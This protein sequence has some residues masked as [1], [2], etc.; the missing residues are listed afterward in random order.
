MLRT[1]YRMTYKNAKSFFGKNSLNVSNVKA[2]FKKKIT[3][4]LAFLCLFAENDILH[5]TLSNFPGI[6]NLNGLNDLSSLNNLSGLYNLISSR[7]LYF[8]KKYI[9]LMVSHFYYLKKAPKVKIEE[10]SN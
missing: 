6:K 10:L 7:N 9:F 8:K 3:M 5:Y 2:I 1:L 4:F